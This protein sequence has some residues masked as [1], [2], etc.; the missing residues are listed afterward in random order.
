MVISTVGFIVF[1]VPFI[2]L[3]IMA[4][5][6]KQNEPQKPEELCIDEDFPVYKYKGSGYVMMLTIVYFLLFIGSLSLAVAFSSKEYEAAAYGIVL[7]PVCIPSAVI[8]ALKAR[9]TKKEV[10]QLLTKINKEGIWLHGT[11]FD[12]DKI[13]VDTF[14]VTPWED[15]LEVFVESISRGG[16]S[17]G[18]QVRDN[19][20]EN[21]SRRVY[22][23]CGEY[24]AEYLKA[25]IERYSAEAYN[26]GLRS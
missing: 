4:D 20:K 24:T 17:L 2:Y 9:R 12:K 6:G 5:G 8:L 13:W 10:D 19:S 14:E 22:L 16:Y 25:V 21:G 23:P 26:C 7:C 18:I 1:W 3:Y 11:K 15:I